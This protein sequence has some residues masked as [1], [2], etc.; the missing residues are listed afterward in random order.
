MAHKKLWHGMTNISAINLRHKNL[1][2]YKNS[3]I[4]MKICEPCCQMACHVIVTWKIELLLIKKDNNIFN[5]IIN[6]INSSNQ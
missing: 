6:E 4:A 5:Q 3:W 1:W 2:C